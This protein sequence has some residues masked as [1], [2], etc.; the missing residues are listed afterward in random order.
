MAITAAITREIAAVRSPVG[1]RV[2]LYAEALALSTNGLP[3]VAELGLHDIRYRLA[4]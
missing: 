3:Q 1:L 4:G 2:T